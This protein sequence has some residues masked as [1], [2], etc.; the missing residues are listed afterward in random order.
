MMKSPLCKFVGMAAWLLTALC[1]THE[2]LMALGYDVWAK[3]GIGAE[4]AKMLAYVFGV[5]GVV[6]LVMFFMML[7]SR[8]C[9]C[10]SNKCS[11]AECND[12]RSMGG[13]KK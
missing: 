7:F 4:T 3:L 8:R 6:S 9:C 13:F 11:G 2:G 5:A 1:A 12:N 10:G